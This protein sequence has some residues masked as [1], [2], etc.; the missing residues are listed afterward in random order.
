MIGEIPSKINPVL[1]L[2]GKYAACRDETA[3]PKSLQLIA[4]ISR[5]F[6]I[7]DI[8]VHQSAPS[9]IPVN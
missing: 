9:G 8:A 6:S 3:R 4:L 7:G 5:T 1:E 2:E